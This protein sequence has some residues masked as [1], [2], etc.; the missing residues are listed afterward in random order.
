MDS[1]KPRE[2]SS[3]KGDGRIVCVKYT[4]FALES[5]NKA[6]CFSLQE[7]LVPQKDLERNSR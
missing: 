1:K 4:N 3:M 2:R 6:L 5:C 7:F